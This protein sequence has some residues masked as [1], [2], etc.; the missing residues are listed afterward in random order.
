MKTINGQYMFLV[1]MASIVAACTLLLTACDKANSSN[2]V[3]AEDFAKQLIARVNEGDYGYVWDHAT[4]ESQNNIEEGFKK[5]K[6]SNRDGLVSGFGIPRNE[7]DTI[8]TKVYFVDVMSA[9]RNAMVKLNNGIQGHISLVRV[10]KQDKS[11]IIT[12]KQNDK[13]ATCR[14][15]KINGEWKIDLPKCDSL[16]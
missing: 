7:I 14:L 5:D 10:E 9:T 3:S 1:K 8:S 16:M 2:E 6:S 12:S 4:Q 15:N 13:D 11:A